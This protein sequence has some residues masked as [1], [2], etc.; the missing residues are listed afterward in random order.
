MKDIYR[1]LCES[2]PSIP[3]FSRAWWLDTVAGENWDVV[4][5]EKGG[6][7]VAAMPYAWKQRY[8]FTVIS[9][10]PLTQTL[11]PW[12]K[13]TNAK[14]AKRL[15]REKDL[16]E[17]L[18][19]QLPSYHQLSQN[20]HFQQ[21]NWLP[22]YWKG[23][24]QTT[25][26]TYRI[27]DLPG[28]GEDEIWSAFQQNIRTDIK[29][30]SNR[31]RLVIRDDLPIESFY[32]LNAMVFRRQGKKM[33]YTKSFIKHLDMAAKEHGCRKVLVA[34]DDQGR[35]HAGVYIVWDENSAYY[36]MGGGNPDLRN[37]GATSLCM[38][39]AIKFASTVTQNFDFEG[40][41]LQP[42]ERFFRSFGAVQTPYFNVTHT[43]ST[44]VRLIN[45]LREIVR[46]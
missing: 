29:K 37:S 34:E 20:W 44:S 32:D 22:F 3:F 7:V 28:K 15:S 35:H 40:S 25:R 9:Q 21:T 24:S 33:P 45:A 1:Q 13:P 12:V 2:E 19:D 23:F 5:V 8:G 31:E 16:M 36:I 42:V 30:A 39:E 6:D 4:L 10:P 11:G 27:T 43:P 38:W 46:P 14:Y 17:A 26:Y 18:V 41:M